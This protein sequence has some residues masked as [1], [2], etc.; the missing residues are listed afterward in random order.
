MNSGI[1]KGKKIAITAYDLQQKEHRGIAQYTKNLIKVL[2]E[3]GAEIYLITNIGSQRIRRNK[4]K[5]F[6]EEVCIADICYTFQQGSLTQGDSYRKKRMQFLKEI[7]LSY[8][9]LLFNRF[10]LNYKFIKFN[11]TQK[12]THIS[13]FK[14]EFL[15]Y[16]SGFIIVKGIFS[17]S[18]LRSIRFLHKIPQLNFKRDEIDLVIS[19]CPLCIRNKNNEYAPIIQIIYDAIPVQDPNYLRPSKF[20]NTLIDAHKNKCLYISSSAQDIVRNLLQISKNLNEI[21]ILRPLPSISSEILNDSLNIKS[22]LGVNKPFILIN[23]SIV[24]W[25]KIEKGIHFFNESNLSDRGFI[26][27]IAGQTHNTKYSKYIQELCSKNKNI[28]LLGYVSEAEKVW[29]YLNT[30]LLISTSVTEGFGIPVLDAGSLGV[31]VIAS[32]IPSFI[33][34][35]KVINNNKISLFDLSEETK[36][37][38]SLNKTEIFNIDNAKAKKSRIKKYSKFCKIAKEETTLKIKNQIDDYIH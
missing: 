14:F 37:L 7:L 18:F 6:F 36:W 28:L 17:L 34:I 21:N 19:S 33:E 8:I 1:L 31:P 5:S 26:L 16:I 32:K 9:R 27:C 22:I 4:N 3:N 13:E 10:K 24:S 35:Q 11:D 15:N 30:S 38:N 2:Y 25:K 12:K 29:L 20:F 23:C